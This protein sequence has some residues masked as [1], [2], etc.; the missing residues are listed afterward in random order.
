LLQ[1]GNHDSSASFNFH[2]HALTDAQPKVSTYVKYT[3][4]VL[5][6]TSNKNI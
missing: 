6:A 3:K 2:R 5:S 4:L 1:T